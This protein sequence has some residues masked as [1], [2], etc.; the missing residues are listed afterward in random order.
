VHN[1]SFAE[2]SVQMVRRVGEIVSGGSTLLGAPIRRVDVL[3]QVAGA[4]TGAVNV[5]VRRGT[6]DSVALA[7]GTIEAQSLSAETQRYSFEATTSYELAANDKILVEWE[8]TP[9]SADQVLV[10][11]NVAQS[12]DSSF[13]GAE[14][15]Q[16]HM[17]HGE[18]EYKTWLEA[19]IAG[20]W[21]CAH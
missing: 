12:G 18:T 3:L 11:R 17:Y 21:W 6:D 9:S 19:D 10:L 1:G 15:F 4:P 20:Q 5:V 13:G 8:G 16:V 7:L 14:L 2:L